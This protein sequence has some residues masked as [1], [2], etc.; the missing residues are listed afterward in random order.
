MSTNP[1]LGTH[2]SN[3]RSRFSSVEEISDEACL[4]LNNVMHGRYVGPE[5]IHEFMARE[6]PE[7]QDMTFPL[8]DFSKVL[9]GAKIEADMYERLVSGVLGSQC[10]LLLTT[11]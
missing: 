4:R 9:P 3:S 7:A 2:A 5:D 1:Q 11:L 10:C 6:M 8:L